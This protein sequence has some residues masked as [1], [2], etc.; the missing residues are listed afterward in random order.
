MLSLLELFAGAE[1]YGK[2][3][4]RMGFKTMSVDKYIE[5][6]FTMDIQEVTREMIVKYIGGDPSAIVASPVCSAWSKTGWFQYW[7]SKA[8]KRSGLFVPKKPFAEESV[9]M[10]KKTIEIFSWFPKAVWWMENPEGMLFRHPVMNE[11]VLHGFGPTVRREKVTYCKYGFGYMKPTHIWTNSPNW[12]PR[13]H[14]V[15]GDTCHTA[16]PRDGKTSGVM[17]MKDSFIRSVIP[18]ELC[19]E[20][21]TSVT[22][23]EH[24]GTGPDTGLQRGSR[25]TG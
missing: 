12:I 25:M 20:I 5:T 24:K 14:C 3:A 10:V 21:L 15:N 22:R 2:V 13:P 1:S 7:D 18:R 23:L 17:N 9:R 4:R 19:E 11:F 16:V 8:Y 6:D